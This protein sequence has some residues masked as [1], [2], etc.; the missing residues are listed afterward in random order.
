MPKEAY[1]KDFI[2]FYNC[3]FLVSIS[4]IIYR[5]L[6]LIQIPICII[7]LICQLKFR[8]IFNILVAIIFSVFGSS[9]RYHSGRTA[10][11]KIPS[12]EEADRST[13]ANLAWQF[14]WSWQSQFSLKSIDIIDYSKYYQ[15]HR[16]NIVWVVEKYRGGGVHCLFEIW[17]FLQCAEAQRGGL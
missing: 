3:I 12:H 16:N 5:G 11:S 1:Q 8:N 9:L 15:P 14:S 2:K 4:C 6:P 10:D 17:F 7:S 13:C